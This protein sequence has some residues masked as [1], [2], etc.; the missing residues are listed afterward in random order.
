ML[1]VSDE[2]PAP[3]TQPSGALT[4][5]LASLLD[6]TTERFRKDA[7][8]TDITDG[9]R[10]SLRPEQPLQLTLFTYNDAGDAVGWNGAS[11]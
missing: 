4:P 6:T 5:G 2:R 3:P 8:Y 7:V 10:A 11:L 9:N 1:H